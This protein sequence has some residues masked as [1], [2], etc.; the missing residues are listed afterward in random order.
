MSEGRA[1]R[2]FLGQTLE[3]QPAQHLCFVWL[4][5]FLFFCLFFFFF[6]LFWLSCLVSSLSLFFFFCQP[7][8]PRFV[9][10]VFGHATWC[11]TAATDGKLLLLLVLHRLVVV[12]VVVAVLELLLLLLLLLFSLLQFSVPCFLKTKFVYLRLLS[13]L[14][15]EKGKRICIG[16]PHR[17]CAV[18]FSQRRLGTYSFTCCR[19]FFFFLLFW[20]CV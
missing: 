18:L 11:C 8:P 7:T 3:R 4:F 19:F 1:S 15:V 9:N 17:C 10:C 13:K 2:H 16:G 6:V 5:V 20:R 14:L 12:V